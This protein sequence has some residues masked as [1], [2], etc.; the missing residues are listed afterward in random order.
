MRRHE[1]L[2]KKGVSKSE[3][4]VVLLIV[5]VVVAILTTIVVDLIYFTDVDM[6]IALNSRNRVKAGY[7]AKSGIYLV[8]GAL[9]EKTLE[10]LAGFTSI[11]DSRTD[12]RNGLWS[13]RVPQY[14][15]GDGIVSLEVLDERSKINLNALV[16]QRSNIVDKQVKVQIEELSRFLNVDGG[17]SRDFVASLINWLDRPIKGAKNDQEANGAREGY[18]MGLSSPYRIK[19]GP[20]DSVEEI[21]LIR[22]MD[23]EYY[24]KIKDFVT[25]YP[26]DKRVSFSTAPVIVMKAVLKSATVSAIGRQTT[27]DPSDVPDDVAESIAEAIIEERADNPVIDRKKVNEIIKDVDPTLLIAAGISGV[28]QLNGKSDVFSVK[29]R[30]MLGDVDPTVKSVLAV[31]YKPASSGNKSNPPKV[32]II[33]WKEL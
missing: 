29:A 11:L 1:N 19:D 23:D 9:R 4:G 32:E 8:A 20:L 10:E 26:P 22:G 18:Y 30:A 21:K 7:L 25:I 14:P 33:S 15:I 5:L 6:E 13:I 12:D 27:G 24:A 16:N 17:K 31:L 28:V 2:I 3:R